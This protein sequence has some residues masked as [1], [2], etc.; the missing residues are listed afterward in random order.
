MVEQI[1]NE[2]SAYGDTV[3]DVID[4]RKNYQIGGM[5]IPIL[6][7]ID[8]TVRSGEYLAV[9]GPSG[10]GERWTNKK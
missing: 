3:I 9:M 4:V 6:N 10:S 5:E 1:V 2:S 7:G 8:I